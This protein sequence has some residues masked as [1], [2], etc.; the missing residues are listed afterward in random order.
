VRRDLPLRPACGRI[1][2]HQCGPGKLQAKRLGKFQPG[3]AGPLRAPVCRRLRGPVRNLLEIVRRLRP[4]EPRV[5]VLRRLRGRP[6]L[7]EIVDRC[8]PAIAVRSLAPRRE[9]IGRAARG[10]GSRCVRLRAAGLGA[11]A[12]AIHRAQRRRAEHRID[13]LSS[14]AGPCPRV[15]GRG[16]V[17]PDVPGCFRP[18]RMP[19][20]L[21][22]PS[23]ANRCIRASRPRGSDQ[24][25][26]ISASK[27]VSASCTPPVNVRDLATGDPPRR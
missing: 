22:R 5:R 24:A 3:L 2:K 13:L 6:Y 26:R 23:R 14:A 18:C 7:Q 9:A 4:P 21:P 19:R 16:R 10:R 15:R 8:P 27:R 17:R 11:L 25:A 20:P 1:P 12:E